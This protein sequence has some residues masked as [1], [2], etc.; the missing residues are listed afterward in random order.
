[1]STG[2]SGSGRQRSAVP[3]EVSDIGEIADTLGLLLFALSLLQAGVLAAAA[4]SGAVGVG[5]WPV[6]VVL[7]AVGLVGGLA[8]A[9]GVPAAGLAAAF[10]KFPRYTDRAITLVGRVLVVVYVVEVVV[11]AS[12]AA[13]GVRVSLPAILTP[14]VGSGPLLAVLYAFPLA[15]ALGLFYYARQNA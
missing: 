5:F 6:D 4:A 14:P 9:L 8:I 15:V 3:T 13:F 2:V 12:A 10:W 7:S 11:L 1:M